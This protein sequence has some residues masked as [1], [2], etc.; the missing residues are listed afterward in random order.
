M[1]ES[2]KIKYQSLSPYLDEHSR[3]I[4]AATEAYLLGHGCIT[5]LARITG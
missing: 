2:I 3:R 4:W 1:L 5:M